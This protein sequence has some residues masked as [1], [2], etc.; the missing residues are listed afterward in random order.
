MEGAQRAATLLSSFTRGAPTASL[1]P[2]KAGARSA[3]GAGAAAPR[4]AGKSKVRRSCRMLLQAGP[5]MS[6]KAGG[7]LA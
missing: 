5:A 2:T 1:M 4:A 7:V 6:T 3:S